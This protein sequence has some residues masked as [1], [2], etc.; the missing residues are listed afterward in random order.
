MAG[1]VGSGFGRKGLERGKLRKLCKGRGSR[2]E[3]GAPG[4][5]WDI[6]GR[7]TVV[8]FIGWILTLVVTAA[9]PFSIK[10]RLWN[11]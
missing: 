11:V 9:T 7:Q 10:R 3:P 8:T 5:D 2:V 1:E 6:L 4:D